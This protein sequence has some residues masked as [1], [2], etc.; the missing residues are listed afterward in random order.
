M[1]GAP[2]LPFWL[3]QLL[4]FVLLVSPGIAFVLAYAADDGA[5]SARAILLV[6]LGLAGLGSM[7]VGALLALTGVLPS[8]TAGGAG[9]VPSPLGSADIFPALSTL[10]GATIVLGALSLVL[11]VPAVRRPIARLIPI[12]PDRLVHLV[13]LD[14]VVLVIW[15]SGAIA[16]FMP[17]IAA[18]PEG[19]KS[20]GDATAQA[21]LTGIWV[22][23]AAFAVLA[24]VGV[25]ALVHRDGRA[26]LDRLGL[27]VVFSWRWW[28][29]GAALALAVAVATDQLWTLADPE[30]AAALG[31]LSDQLFGPLIAKGGIAAALTI[32]L[33]PGIGEE[34]LF[35]GAAQPRLG[36]V[37][38]SLL[39]AAMHTQYTVSPALIQIFIVGL[40]L[41]RVRQRAGTG[42]SILVHATFNALQVAISLIGG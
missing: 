42:T 24:V 34:L 23:N 25:G 26:V 35:R 37:F 20:L 39:F 4:T 1:S 28:L 33:A 31:K 6:G 7:F 9:D 10:G 5:R 38:T 29:G 13:A 22:Q 15:M 14:C 3:E 12:D 17:I 2:S 27:N 41:G 8:L 18:D 16:L 19:M 21:G 40:I 36:L 11:L 30:G 32:G